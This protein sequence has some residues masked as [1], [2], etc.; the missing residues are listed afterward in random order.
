MDSLTE[1]FAAVHVSSA[2]QARIEASAPWGLERRDGESAAAYAYAHFAYVSRGSCY[3]SVAGGD[4]IALVGGDCVLMAPNTVY[5]LRDQ[6]GSPVASFCSLPRGDMESG[7]RIG[8][9]GA[10][11]TIVNGWFTLDPKGGR[12]TDLLPPMILIRGDQARSQT[13]VT[14]LQMLT[15]E[16]TSPS[17]G[18]E[19]VVQRLADVLFIQ[20]LRAF[21]ASGSCTETP[22]FLRALADPRI[23]KSLDAMHRELAKPWTL[24]TLASAAGMSRS[25][26]AAR[27]KALL[28]ETPM[29]YLTRWRMQTAGRLLSDLTWNPKYSAVAQSVGYRHGAAFTRA[30]ER[31]FGVSPHSWRNQHIH[32]ARFVVSNEESPSGVND[33]I[34]RPPPVA[35]AIGP[36]ADEID[37]RRVRRGE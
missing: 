30:F 27:F 19:V 2:V 9:G 29:E 16:L 22:R 28:D 33:H 18:S 10:T 3:L 31:V 1:V 13:L 15:T 8:G 21:A 7:I 4:P 17:P 35:A 12:F 26:F 37:G 20:A 5:A 34:N 36:S 24:A 25:A 11:T 6:P 23:G 32:R 14:T